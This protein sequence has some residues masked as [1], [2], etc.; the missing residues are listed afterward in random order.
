[1]KRAILFLIIGSIPLFFS[2]RKNKEFIN[3]ST[4]VTEDNNNIQS[5]SDAAT[6][7]ANSA[8]SDLGSLAGKNVSAEAL[9]AF[10]LCGVVVDTTQKAS[11]VLTLNYDGTT[12]CKNR[13]RSGSIKATLEGFITGIRWKHTGAVIKLEFN[14]FKVTRAS[15]S[16]SLEFSGI[17]Y[18]TNISGGNLALLFLGMQTNFVTSVSGADLKVKFDDGKIATC[19]VNRKFTY[20]MSGQVISC[21]V[22]GIG[23]NNGLSGLENYGTTRNGDTF[24]S[25]VLT[26][27]VWNTDCRTYVLAGKLN[28]KVPAKVFDL[29]TTFG[30]DESG[31]VV[32]PSA[33][34]CPYGMKL[35]WTRKSKKNSKIVKYN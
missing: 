5:Q 3:E 24:T 26:P 33:N 16:K 7:D 22:E 1:M 29:V 11:G 12:V 6:S 21:T 4:E 8:I 25:Q 14:N 15:D 34:N 9:E 23:T 20:A 31:N 28:V 19:N 30:V 10:A 17:K 27:I 32:T 13:K 18:M 2:C 35:E